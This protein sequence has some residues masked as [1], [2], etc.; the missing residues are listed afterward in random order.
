MNS[1]VD[2]SIVWARRTSNEIYWPGRIL[3]QHHESLSTSANNYY[4]IQLFVNQ[5]SIWTEDLLPY[6]QYRESM[7]N[8]SYIQYNLH[9]TVKQDFFNAVQQADFALNQSTTM[10]K[11]VKNDYLSDKDEGLLSLIEDKTENDFLSMP[12]PMFHSDTGK[13]KRFS[14]RSTHRL[15]SYRRSEYIIVV[16]V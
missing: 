15:S 12:M 6:S 10:T 3:G 11:T 5:Q 14:N 2:Q 8:N 13:I 1:F 9:P 16:H 7:T 4:H